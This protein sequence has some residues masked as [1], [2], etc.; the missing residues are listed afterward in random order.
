MMAAVSRKVV[1]VLMVMLRIRR[2]TKR[3]TAES[4]YREDGAAC[5]ACKL[6]KVMAENGEEE[7]AGI[8]DRLGVVGDGSRHGPVERFRA[9][10]TDG[11]EPPALSPT[12]FLL[13]RGRFAKLGNV[14]EVGVARW[15]Q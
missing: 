14:I 2:R 7:I 6:E 1:T 9:R 3:G 4:S 12:A 8:I 15:Q 13:L 5:Q 11:L 10:S